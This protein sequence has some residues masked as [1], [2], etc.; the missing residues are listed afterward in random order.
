MGLRTP[1]QCILRV[2][3]AAVLAATPHADCLL[4]AASHSATYQHTYT[5]DT[6]TAE[7][8]CDLPPELVPKILV[9][10]PLPE[11]LRDAAL[12]SQAWR[13]AAVAVMTTLSVKVDSSKQEPLLAWLN[14]NAEQVVSLDLFARVGDTYDDCL[15]LDLPLERLS[16]LQ[17]L[18][19]EGVELPPVA[20]DTEDSPAGRPQQQQQT[21]SSTS[22]S[23]TSSST[24]STTPNTPP[25]LLPQ[26]KEI[27]IRH[28]R[29]QSAQCLV[30]LCS[31]NSL[32]SLK[33]AT[34]SGMSPWG[35]GPSSWRRARQYMSFS[36]AILTVMQRHQA[37][38]RV[39]HVSHR[40]GDLGME[41]MGDAKFAGTLSAMQIEDM[42]LP[43]RDQSSRS[44]LADLPA[45]LTRLLVRDNSLRGLYGPA[46]PSLPRLVQPHSNLLHLTMTECS[47]DSGV[48]ADMTQL[49][50]L[51]LLLCN[52]LPAGLGGE[53][54][55]SFLSALP[56]LPRLQHLQLA[57]LGTTGL[58][59]AQPPYSAFSALTASSQ[60]TTL[61]VREGGSPPVPLGSVQFIFPAGR[62]LPQLHSLTLLDPTGGSEGAWCLDSEDVGCIVDCCPN[63]ATLDIRNVVQPDADLSALERA[64]TAWLARL[65]RLRLYSS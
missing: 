8:S 47:V 4:S 25:L 31:S 24:T 34:A 57:N 59:Y 1:G 49:Q 60:L 20:R 30:Q 44:A 62:R 64:A 45:C 28:C 23:S 39:L 54:I 9:H 37:S 27:E 6:S 22:S 32:T 5:Q 52:F 7:L 38:L 10:L 46:A 58:R 51:D 2:L 36:T 18:K 29:L 17:Y 21:S 48:F 26:L 19:L 50:H 35:Y 53:G 61:H 42:R 13:D 16:S 14:K 63:L 3:S 15:V 33:V 55:A 11:R 41:Q 56:A 40:M 12:V 65:M 43:V